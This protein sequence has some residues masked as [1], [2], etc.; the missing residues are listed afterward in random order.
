MKIMKRILGVVFC[1]VLFASTI[2][3][4]SVKEV[5]ADTTYN[6][7]EIEDMQLNKARIKTNSADSN[8]KHVETYWQQDPLDTYDKLTD[9]TFARTVL[10]AGEAGDYIFQI[11]C[12]NETGGGSIG[13]KLYV[14]GTA[15]DITVSGTSYQTVNKTVTLAKGKNS[16]ILAWVNWGYFDYINYPSELKLVSR[17]TDRKYYAVESALNEIQLTPTNGFHNP[18]ASLYTAPIEYNS[19]DEEWQGA[20]TFTADV[21]AN[22]KSIDLNYYVTE[23]NNGKAQ[24][25]MSVNGGSE[26]KLDLSGTKTN[27]ELTYSISTKTLT[28]AGF[29]AGQKNTIK[30]RQASSTGGK[31]GLYSIELK[32]E[33]VEQTTPAP[34]KANRYEAENAYIISGAKIKTAESDEENWSK[35][36]YIGEFT[37]AVITKP[38]QIDEYCSNI[39]YV[40]YQVQADQKGY[41]KVTLGYA[42][43]EDMSVYVTSG[44]EWSK[45]N[46]TS[47]GKWCDVGEKYTYVYLK[48]GTNSIWVTGPT[49]EKGWVNYDY[50]DVEFDEAADIDTSDTVL[51]LDN[52]ASS[53]NSK[54]VSNGEET[55]TKSKDTD[56]E[57]EDENDEEDSLVSPKTGTSVIVGLAI[58]LLA[59]AGFAV[60]Y[61]KKGLIK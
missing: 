56:S 13:I 60:T 28:D 30:F 24:L 1:I 21:P 14:N 40:Q 2:T 12:K 57:A 58:V 44:Y 41:Y 5:K 39:G 32:E 54:V 26:V 42:S 29:K 7:L 18:E 47:T 33:Q 43:E 23:Y 31:V 61:K 51:L 3:V 11:H 35:G 15:Y 38:S 48:K 36:S 4:G 45:V 55:T 52:G 37:P 46:L 50:I 19:G 10:E 6:K 16:I 17:N 20:A 8:G 49:T 53:S 34:S 22:I 27:T 59:T 9:I 25:A